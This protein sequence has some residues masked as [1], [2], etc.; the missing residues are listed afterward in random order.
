MK[1]SD[2]PLEFFNFLPN[3]VVWSESYQKP[4]LVTKSFPW[5]FLKIKKFAKA[6]EH[7]NTWQKTLKKS[8][9]RI[10]LQ[11]HWN[12]VTAM[13]YSVCACSVTCVQLF[14]TL[15]TVARQAPLSVGILH[16][17]ILEWVAMAS[18]SRSSGWN[19]CILCLLHWQVGYSL[20]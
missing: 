10:Q 11:C 2:F 18:F 20:R 3:S 15:W 14:A 4:A 13:T 17:R 8:G 1:S 7:N 19:L 12:L 5:I 16:A 6:S 9:L